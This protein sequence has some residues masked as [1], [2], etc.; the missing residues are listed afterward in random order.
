MLVCEDKD[1]QTELENTQERHKEESV[2]QVCEMHKDEA[3]DSISNQ[4]LGVLHSA[5]PS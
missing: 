2:D 1:R 5:V 3:T 4:T